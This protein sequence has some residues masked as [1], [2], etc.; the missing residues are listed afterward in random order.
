MSPLSHPA[1][2]PIMRRIARTLPLAIALEAAI[3]RFSAADY[4]AQVDGDAIEEDS[5]RP[6]A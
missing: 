4:A 3:F 1:S 5:W 6:T 2:G